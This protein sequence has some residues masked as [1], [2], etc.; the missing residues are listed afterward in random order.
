MLRLK[1]FLVLTSDKKIFDLDSAKSLIDEDD[2][3]IESFL[4]QN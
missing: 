2:K 3:K 1:E 4:F